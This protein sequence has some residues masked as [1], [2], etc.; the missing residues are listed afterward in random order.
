VLDYLLR[1][2]GSF[3]PNVVAPPDGGRPPV[4]AGT[5]LPRPAR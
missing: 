4:F 3:N 1:L 5:G 2:Q